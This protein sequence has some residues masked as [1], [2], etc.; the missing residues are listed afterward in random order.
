VAAAASMGRPVRVHL[1]PV[2]L[3]AQGVRFTHLVQQGLSRHPSVVLVPPLPETLHATTVSAT[4]IYFTLVS[5]VRTAAA[6]ADLA[7]ND[8]APC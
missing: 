2:D 8:D 7:P 5:H 3:P 1:V 6:T 4:F